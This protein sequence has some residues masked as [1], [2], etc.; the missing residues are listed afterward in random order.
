[1]TLCFFLKI[2]CDL[3]YYFVYAGLVADSFGQ[4]HLQFP[5]I[6]GC[7]LVAALCWTL[8]DKYPYKRRH[9]LPLLLLPLLFLLPAQSIGRMVLAPAALYVVWVVVTDRVHH[10]YYDA[11]E[12]FRLELKLLP[13]PLAYLFFLQEFGPGGASSSPV[14]LL[15]FLLGSVFYLRTV[16]H[17]ENTL[18]QPRFRLLNSL[19]L[20]AVCLVTLVLVSPWF[21][22]AFLLMVKGGIRVLLLPLLAI[23]LLVGTGIGLLFEQLI[24]EDFHFEAEKLLELLGDLSAEQGDLA[25]GIEQI[26]SDGSQTVQTIFT[27]LGA[28]LALAFAFWL[29]RKLASARRKDG[30]QPEGSQTRY[31]AVPVPSKEEV[32]MTLLKARTPALQV[33]YWYRQFLKKTLREGGALTDVMDTRQQKTAAGDV[34]HRQEEA[35]S[36]LRALYLPARYRD[37]ATAEDAKAARELVKQ[38][39]SD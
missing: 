21:R 35:L 20:G 17:D 10:N 24:P 27:A 33:R 3:S 31:A 1:M 16:R 13:L 22:S 8:W 2:F 4:Q 36:R 39:E 19:S 32:P 28:I 25:E 14:Y 26:P 7:A 29:F 30:Y 18:R 15:T 12:L 38:L 37:T 23:A 34:F 9:W 11:A 5:G 6:V